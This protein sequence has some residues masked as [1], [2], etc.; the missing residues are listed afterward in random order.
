[1]KKDENKDIV[2]YLLGDKGLLKAKDVTQKALLQLKTNLKML[3]T[4]KVRLEKD[5]KV[6]ENEILKTEVALRS[7]DD[8]NSTLEDILDS[9]GLSKLQVVLKGNEDGTVKASLETVQSTSPTKCLYVDPRGKKC[10]R[11]L[12][13]SEEKKNLHCQLHWDLLCRGET[14]EIKPLKL[15]KKKTSS[16]K[17]TESKKK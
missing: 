15:L 14:P 4:Q 13:T 12:N 11:R 2:E 9:S 1:M 17:K 16:K 6:N 5:L 10:S 3:Q 8:F 7:Y